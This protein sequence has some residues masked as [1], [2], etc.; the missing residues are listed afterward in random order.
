LTSGAK[1]QLPPSG[2]FL[3]G[4]NLMDMPATPEKTYALDFVERNRQALALLSDSVFYFGELGMQEHRSAQLMS[5]ILEEHGF[6]V[7]RGI[8]GFPTGFMATYGKGSP[9]IAMHTEY[10]ANPSNSQKAGVAEPAEITPSA[11]GHCEGHNVNAAVMVS[12]ALALRHAMERFKIPGT[13]KV[14][15]AP[16]E[17]QL[18]SRPYF[19]RDGYFDDVDLAFHDHISSDLRTDY[20]LTQSA[21][22]SATFNFRGESAHASVAPWK[23]RDALDGVVL[24][25]MGM[26]QYREHMMPTM[27]AQRVI[28]NGGEQP[29]VIPAKAAVWWYF[30]DANAEGARKL[31]EQAKKIAQGAALMTNTEVDVEVMAAVWP[32]RGNQVMAEAV[33]RNIETIGLPTWTSEEQALA[34]ALQKRAGVKEDG[35]RRSPAPLTGPSKQG[36]S[37]N[38]SGDVSWKVPMVRVQFPAN[39]PGISYHH[40]AAGAALATTIAHKGGLAGA[41]TLAASVLDFLKDP[42]LVAAAKEGF[43]KETGG[44][45]YRSLLPEG[46]KPPVE[47]NAIAMAKFR[48]QMEAHY[49]R[50]RPVFK[51]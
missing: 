2:R 45:P 26:A 20:G 25:D 49:V 9:V 44:V 14:F 48:P 43:Q 15:G 12:A 10:D 51:V 50:E 29:N 8:S 11:P 28:T 35:L 21:M 37:S 18:I 30:R 17:E 41:K 19:V 39:V 4:V 16:A 38:D 40:W 5:G 34:I 6:A 32:S 46:Q 33:Q 27:S 47:L 3:S 36:P 24:M 7:E 1:V 22:I 13:L 23:G 42:A 31:F